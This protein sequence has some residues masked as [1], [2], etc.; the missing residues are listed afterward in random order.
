MTNEEKRFLLNDSII[1]VSTPKTGFGETMKNKDL[2][3]TSLMLVRKI[4]GFECKQ[5]LRVLFDTGGTRT[6]INKRV[7]PPE[8]TIVESQKRYEVET[9]NGKFNA[10][11]FVHLRDL[12]FPEF[13]KSKRIYGKRVQIFDNPNSSH[14]II[15]GRD[16]LLD[17]G[18]VF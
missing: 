15:L 14:D 11:K 7:V 10:N 9:A 18:F 1:Q 6:M 12:Y 2:A 13:D 16:Y 8:A 5:L 3:P 17:L 4:G